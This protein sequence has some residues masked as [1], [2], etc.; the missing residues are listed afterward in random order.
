MPV[1]LA[2]EVT[3]VVLAA[4]VTPVVFVAEVPLDA[5]V[6]APLLVFE[7]GS[8]PA[9]PAPPFD[10]GEGLSFTVGPHDTA[11]ASVSPT[12]ARGR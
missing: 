8:P 7:V 11:T 2:A 1:V 12:A 5:I 3:P 10:D 4:E 6:V 9:P